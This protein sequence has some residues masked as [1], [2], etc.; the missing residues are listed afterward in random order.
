MRKLAQQLLRYFFQGVIIVSPLAVTVWAA[1]TVFD[2]LD[3][4]NENWP[5]GIGFL[6][7]VGS[8]LLIGWL[9]STFFVWKFLIDFFDSILERTPFVKF[10]YTS[11]K[12]VVESFMGDKKKFNKPVLVRVRA[13][14]EIF[15]I[16]FITQSD[17]SKI[18]IEDKIA[19]YMPHAYAVS[20]FLFI[21]NKDDVIPLEMDPS[22]AMK[23][24]VSGGMTGYEDVQEENRRVHH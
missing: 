14:P 23:M 20:G 15:Q 8:L 9:G 18:G 13:N 1:Y 4:K 21:V 19:V 2:F 11:V 16:G 22:R 3:L 6:I 12:D 5:R 24:A 17:L 10:I 7:V